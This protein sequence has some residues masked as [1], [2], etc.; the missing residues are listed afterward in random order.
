M[1]TSRPLTPVPSRRVSSTNPTGI[2]KYGQHHRLLWF[3]LLHRR[4][5]L[6]W[7]VTNVIETFRW[8]APRGGDLYDG[9]HVVWHTEEIRT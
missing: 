3:M 6:V 5:A 2:L 8:P 4:G 1:M 9:L 7:P